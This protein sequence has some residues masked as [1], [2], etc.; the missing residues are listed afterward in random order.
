MKKYIKPQ[1]ET[2]EFEVNDIITASGIFA[3]ITDLDKSKSIDWNDEILDP[4]DTF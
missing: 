4:K 3:G 2:K 1:M